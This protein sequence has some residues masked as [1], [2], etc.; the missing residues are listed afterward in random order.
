VTQDVA[1]LNRLIKVIPACVAGSL[2]TIAIAQES[3]SLWPDQE[4]ASAGG[5]G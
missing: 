1:D 3:D 5:G 4:L 2:H